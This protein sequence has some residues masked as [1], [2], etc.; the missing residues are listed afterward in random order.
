MNQ[1]HAY[2]WAEV[3]KLLAEPACL[4]ML[5]VVIKKAEYTSAEELAEAAKIPTSKA[6]AFL[7]EM[8]DEYILDREQINDEDHYKLTSGS[9]ADFVEMLINKIS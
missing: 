4:I 2:K 8:C 1:S 3:F 9:Q 7:D 5:Y 6:R